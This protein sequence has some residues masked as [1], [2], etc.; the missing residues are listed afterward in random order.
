MATGSFSYGMSSY[1]GGY[2]TIKIE[3]S[4]TKSLIQGVEYQYQILGNSGPD[5][6]YVA[7]AERIQGRLFLIDNNFT[8]D[9]KDPPFTPGRP[10]VIYVPGTG[11]P[12][13]ETM[14]TNITPFEQESKQQQTTF[15]TETINQTTGETLIIKVYDGSNLRKFNGMQSIPINEF[16]ENNK[17]IP[18]IQIDE[19]STNGQTVSTYTS[20]IKNKFGKK[21]QKK[22]KK[23][24]KKF[25]LFK[26]DSKSNVSAKSDTSN[27]FTEIKG[28]TDY[29]IM[30]DDPDN[31]LG[32]FWEISYIGTP[33]PPPPMYEEEPIEPIPASFPPAY[34]NSNNEGVEGLLTGR[35]CSNCQF[36]EAESGNCSKWNAIARDYYWCAAW[37]TM[38]P[39]IAQP[40]EFTSRISQTSNSEDELYNF[41]IERVKDPISQEPNL[42]NFL[43]PLNALHST[44]NAYLYGDSLRRMVDSGNAYD[45]DNVPL[46]FFFTDQDKF[47]SAIDFINNGGLSEF[48]IPEEEYDSVQQHLC[49]YTLNK[50]ESSSLPQEFPQSIIIN[51][52]GNF[53]GSPINILSQ[54]DF[55]NAKIA[56]NP[57]RHVLVDSR[58][59]NYESVGRLHIDLVKPS[60]RERVIKF[61]NDNSKDYNLDN[62]SS[63]KFKQWIADR[64][65]TSERWQD[66]YNYLL[67]I[68]V[69]SS[70]DQQ[71]IELIQ[72]TLGEQL[73]DNPSTT[74]LPF[75]TE[76]LAGEESGV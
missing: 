47:L 15:N 8:I 16:I 58:L 31:I 60:I 14:I 13:L 38:E 17:D 29:N 20:V 23:K 19:L 69:I 66:L 27:T 63:V 74:I 46:N 1:G 39:V 51:L 37:K 68:S 67:T 70:T 28:D 52:Y 50:K 55:T 59:V 30:I 10:I 53:F 43:S 18:I 73:I 5:N 22:K 65:F 54:L 26:S 7:T 76:V 42:S 64:S 2:G 41:F 12:L 24:K 21:G 34:Q 57:S 9:E 71:L 72:N 40:N 35:K 61:L 62:L 75:Q 45:F 4:E 33:P 36:F 6:T 48:D 25:N 44:Y 32:K 56:Y 11:V 49:T 3:L